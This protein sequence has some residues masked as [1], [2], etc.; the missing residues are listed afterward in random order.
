MVLVQ[1]NDIDKLIYNR[2][3][4]PYLPA[5][6][7]DAHTHLFQLRFHPDYVFP[8]GIPAED[9]DMA[10]MQTWWREL[11]PQQNV[12]GLV[13]PFPT[14]NM[15]TQGEN[16]FVAE[17]VTNNRDRFSLVTLPS[18]TAADLEAAIK[19]HKPFGLKP[20]LCFA[21]VPDPQQ[22]EIT[23]FLPE[24]QIALAD[25]YGLAVT[26]HVSKPRGMA[27][28]NN[29]ESINRLVAQ[30]PNCK[31]ILAH[32]GRCF[33]PIN[34]EDTLAKLTVAENL[35]FDTSAVCDMGVFMHLFNKYDRKRICFGTDLVG[36]AAFR[37]QYLRMGMSW[38]M[39]SAEQM[40]RPNG[41][42]IDATYCVY[43][44]L[45][46]LLTATKFSNMNDHDRQRLFYSNA[47]ELFALLHD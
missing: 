5:R 25:K 12:N 46:S 3:I 36:A 9:V 17:Q 13:M 34:M 44:N 39:V 47:A 41:Q 32:C 20:Y 28:Q 42:N 8:K 40:A 14:V 31:F 18:Q 26:I 29:L 43:E 45:R 10:A 37:G 1:I 27:D 11:F 16:N 38:D 7:F 30:Y 2:E 15:D 23:D 35:W 33:I 22:A 19:K 4:A 21:N 24:E 6:I